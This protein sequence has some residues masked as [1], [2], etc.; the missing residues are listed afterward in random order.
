VTVCPPIVTVPDREAPPFAVAVIV[1]VPVPAPLAEVV[2]NE[3]LLDAVHEQLDTV[4]TVMSALPPP[5]LILTLVGATV[6]AHPA[7]AIRFAADCEK[8]TA[9]PFTLM[10]PEREAPVFAAML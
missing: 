4:A 5:L 1:A 8:F 6:T 3:L 7:G 10:L 9:V 2:M